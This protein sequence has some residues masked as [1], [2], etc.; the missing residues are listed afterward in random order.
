M[1]NALTL[2]Q[3]QYPHVHEKIITEVYDASEAGIWLQLAV[4]GEE[5]YWLRKV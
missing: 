3:E 1:L 5:V 4:M 2:I